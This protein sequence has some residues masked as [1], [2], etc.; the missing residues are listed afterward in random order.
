MINDKHFVLFKFWE[1]WCL[2]WWE[3]NVWFYCIISTFWIVLLFCHKLNL[4]C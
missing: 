3:R 4:F 1:N 2:D